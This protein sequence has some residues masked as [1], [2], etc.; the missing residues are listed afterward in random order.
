MVYHRKP[1]PGHE[2]KGKV[3]ILVHGRTWSS[4]PV[5]DLDVATEERGPEH[6]LSLMRVLSELGISSYAVDFRGFGET[7]RDGSG[8]C[9]PSRCVED[10][11]V[12]AR[13][14][15]E[16]SKAEYGLGLDHN[17]AILGWSQ[18]ALVSMLYAQQYPEL[19]S[20]LVLYAS[21]YDQKIV[22]GRKVRLWSARAARPAAPCHFLPLA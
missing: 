13:W 9:T 19:M 3:V 18:G 21:I 16:H 1:K 15:H 2:D 7:P 17:P 5:F 14:S 11:M 20:D 10:L 4:V 6:S 8:F 12:A 22:Y